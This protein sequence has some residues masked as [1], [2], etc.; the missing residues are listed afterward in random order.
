MVIFCDLDGPCEERD[1]ISIS[2]TSVEIAVS[3]GNFV[4]D[5]SRRSGPHVVLLADW[6]LVAVAT[7]VVAFAGRFPRSLDT[8]PCFC[9]HCFFFG[10]NCVFGVTFAHLRSLF[11][12]ACLFFPQDLS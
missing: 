8:S 7:S 3:S 11:Q 4:G 12:L 6:S 1:V 5:F 10:D 9:L 2:P